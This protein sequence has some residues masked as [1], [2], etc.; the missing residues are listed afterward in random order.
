MILL[1]LTLLAG[2]LQPTP[3]VVPPRDGH[4]VTRQVSA[5]CDAGIDTLSLY[6]A[7]LPLDGDNI[8]EAYSDEADPSLD[9][10]DPEEDYAP[11][12]YPE[13]EQCPMLFVIPFDF[14]DGELWFDTS[15]YGPSV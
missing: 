4:A 15:A 11:G 8:P 9:A 2:A 10:Q 6:P 5:P 13:E 14:W 3:V 1:P 7:S 12:E